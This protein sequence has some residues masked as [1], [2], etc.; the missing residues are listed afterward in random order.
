MASNKGYRVGYK[1]SASKALSVKIGRNDVCPC[2]AT[3]DKVF[4]DELGV[5]QVIPVRMKY[6]KC[7]MGKNL[8]YK[9]KEDMERARVLD[10][11]PLKEDNSN[12]ENI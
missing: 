3:V 2:G 7:C 9:S 1:Q 6:K 4:T 10:G 5:E 8:F 12:Q 11:L